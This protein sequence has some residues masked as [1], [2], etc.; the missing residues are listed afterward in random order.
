[1][2]L[3]VYACLY[4]LVYICL[5]IYACLFGDI[6]DRTTVCLMMPNGSGEQLPVLGNLAHGASMLFCQGLW[7]GREFETWQSTAVMGT[8]DNC[9]DNLA[10][11]TYSYC[12]V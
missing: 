11:L 10:P 2:C 3:S 6:I 1:M 5:S 7:G 12:K 9:F 8:C 4:M